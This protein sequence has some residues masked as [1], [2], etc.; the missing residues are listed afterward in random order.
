LSPDS[1]N[2]IDCAVNLSRGLGFQ[3]ALHRYFR[4]LPAEDYVREITS[5]TGLER[6]PETYF[7]PLYPALLAFLIKTGFS[8]ETAAAWL[9]IVCFALNIFTVG[10]LVFRFSRGSPLPA[11]G[12]ALFMLGSESMLFVHT[13]AITEP[14]FILLC[15]AGLAILSAYLERGRLGFLLAGAAVCGLAFLTR[16]IG[17]AL[18]GTGFIGLC[19]FSRKPFLKRLPAAMIFLVLSLLPVAI[20]FPGNSLTIERSPLPPK[21]FS[22]AKASDLP[23]IRSTLSS[24]AFPGSGRIELFSGQNALLS[25]AVAVVLLSIMAGAI[26]SARRDRKT[27]P[28]GGILSGTPLFF[29]LFVP[30][31]LAGFLFAEVSVHGLLVLDM[32]LLSPLFAPLLV[33]TAYVLRGWLGSL[34]NNGIRRVASTVLAAYALVYTGCGIYWMS[35]CHRNGRGYNNRNFQ[36]TEVVQAL[37]TLPALGAVP[38]FTNDCGAIYFQAGRYAY[39]FPCE[40]GIRNPAVLEKAIGIASACFVYYWTPA[41]LEALEKLTEGSRDRFEKG[42]IEALGL[43]ILAKSRMITVLWRPAR[44]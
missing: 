18:I 24:W 10:Y 43:R 5:E 22:I 38:V 37:E 13:S 30:V 17:S 11:V 39:Q 41:H 27:L 20:F 40:R 4:P 7:P 35:V 44:S 29:A 19:M 3:S 21:V 16:Y 15:L 12:A 1:A 9:A 8:A 26:V 2:Y 28:A 6:R 36:A 23:A 34:S 42:L 14:L 32:R 31:Y 25:S 33:T